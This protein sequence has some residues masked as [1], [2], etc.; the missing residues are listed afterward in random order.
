M[1][2]NYNVWII[3]IVW[4]VIGHFY[5]SSNCSITQWL[6]CIELNDVFCIFTRRPGGLAI[7]IRIWAR[8]DWCPRCCCCHRR[9]D[10]SKSSDRAGWKRSSF[11][12]GGRDS[13][14]KFAPEFCRR[15]MWS[16]CRPFHRSC[17]CPWPTVP[18]NPLPVLRS[19]RWI[20]H[21]YR[22]LHHRINQRCLLNEYSTLL[23][24]VLLKH[25]AI[26]NE[27][28][29]LIYRFAD[30]IHIS[31]FFV[32]K[33]IEINVDKYHW[34]HAKGQNWNRKTRIYWNE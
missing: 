16:P 10:D 19:E 21:F 11:H 22:S 31:S 15:P 17:C 24:I 28:C 9:C 5:W 33:T 3:E 29:D 32:F 27:K 13:R 1:R 18:N 6:L 8:V 34:I 2:W 30:N 4:N 23:L 12:F 25:V 20:T 14:R 7:N 26:Q